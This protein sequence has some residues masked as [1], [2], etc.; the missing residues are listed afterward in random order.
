MGQT[1]LYFT[2]SIGKFNNMSWLKARWGI[3]GDRVRWSCG[4]SEGC[5]LD[6][7]R[8]LSVQIHRSIVS[9]KRSE[10]TIWLHQA[11]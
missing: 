11:W 8:V 3:Y 1:E 7:K 4:C 5:G 2:D 6:A 10:L 9:I